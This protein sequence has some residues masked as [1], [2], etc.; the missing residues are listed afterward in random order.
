MSVATGF[1]PARRRPPAAWWSLQ[2]CR[3]STATCTSFR[4]R[5]GDIGETTLQC[6][7]THGRSPDRPAPSHYGFNLRNVVTWQHA[8]ADSYIALG[9]E[10]GLDVESS[11]DVFDELLVGEWV[12]LTLCGSE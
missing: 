1:T 7:Q 12:T 2:I 8:V 6:S 5:G 9:D 10:P 11:E 3:G 4:P